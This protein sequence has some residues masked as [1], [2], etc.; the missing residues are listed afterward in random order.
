MQEAAERSGFPL[1]ASSWSQ[2]EK[3]SIEEV[4]TGYRVNRNKKAKILRR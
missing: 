2:H 3:G 1:E 4:S